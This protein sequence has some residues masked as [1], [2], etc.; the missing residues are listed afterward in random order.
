MKSLPVIGVTMGEASGIGPEILVKALS[1]KSVFEFCRPIAIGDAK[2]L[3]RAKE[4]F[5]A[6]L[7]FSKIGHPS[8]AD[9]ETDKV[10]LI[11]L[12][13][14]PLEKLSP[15][16]HNAVTGRAMLNYTDELIKYY[17]DGSIHGGVG[18]P[19]SKKAAEEAGYNFVGY[20]YYIADMIGRARSVHD[21][22]GGQHESGQHH[23]ARIAQKSPGHD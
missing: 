21:A 4:Q 9:W 7:E 15:G 22:G 14:I 23:P 2:V 12:D 10:N 18:G 16:K 20:P 19:H 3:Q 13:D 5:G 8:E 11:D 1:D 6:P 17:K